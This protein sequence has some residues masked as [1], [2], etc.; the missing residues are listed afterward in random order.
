MNI[1]TSLTIDVSI[2]P[3]RVFTNKEPDD[4][5]IIE[6]PY[7]GR[8]MFVL[9]EGNMLYVHLKDKGRIR[10][11]KRW[12]QVRRSIFV[13]FSKQ[14]HYIFLCIMKLKSLK[15]SL[16]FRRFNIQMNKNELIKWPVMYFVTFQT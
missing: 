5:S 3:F 9:P 11:K 4:V 13:V 10:N 6:T 1:L 15:I 14:H 7:G 8:L 2:P 16:Q 12:S